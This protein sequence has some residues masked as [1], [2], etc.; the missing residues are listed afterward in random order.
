M[1][2]F[3]FVAGAICLSLLTSTAALSRPA[4]DS[5]SPDGRLIL[6]VTFPAGHTP[7]VADE[8]WT[9]RVIAIPGESAEKV[10][11][12][13]ALPSF[14]SSIVARGKLYKF[15]MV[16]GNPFLRNAKKATI[17]VA[18]I[19]VWFV[20]PD[21]TALDPAVP[22]SGCA[23]TGTPLNLALQS[24]IFQ[25]AD[26]GEGGRQF[27][28]E[29]RRLEFWTYTGPGR[30]NP[31]YS[32]RLSVSSNASVRVTLPPGYQTQEAPC[33]RKSVIDLGIWNQ[34][35][36]GIIPLLSRAGITPKTFPVFL[37]L[38]VILDAGDAGMVAGYHSWANAGGVQTYGVAMYDT[39]QSLPS[40]RD[41]SVLSREIAEWLDDPLGN[42]PT[43]PW[44]HIGQ[45]EGCQANL[46]VAD[47]LTGSPLFEVAM[48]NG[49]AYHLQEAAFFSWFYNQVPSLGINGWYSSGGSLTAPAAL[50]H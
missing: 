13:L 12:R 5:A 20:F 1:K 15:T 6:D 16:G 26:Y 42:N 2:C 38:N 44:G 29:M 9:D 23:G 50:C 27:A 11:P 36:Q 8:T 35:L 4:E 18:L 33:G 39:T 3:A 47:P 17:P 32:V 10:A 46:E 41:V 21:G 48:P 31:G 22:N 40:S 25:D 19:P 14:S 49:F 37:F 24:P 34:V 45:V 28:E 30:L 7:R 43:P